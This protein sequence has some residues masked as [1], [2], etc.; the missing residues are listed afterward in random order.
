MAKKN[1]TYAILTEETYDSKISTNCPLI[2]SKFGTKKMGIIY[3]DIDG[4]D[5]EGERK[6]V[7]ENSII[8]DLTF[9]EL[10]KDELNKRIYLPTEVKD[11]EVENEDGTMDLVPSETYIT[12]NG[13]YKQYSIYFCPF[14]E[15]SNIAGQLRELKNL[16][17]KMEAPLNS[18][19]TREEFIAY[20]EKSFH[21]NDK[22]PTIE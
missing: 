6:V 13:K 19:V 5:I 3:E 1:F 7:K 22:I 14:P 2:S 17:V 10:F 16:G 18:V 11:A 4:D 21:R 15:L 12:E 20:Y 9:R 8:K